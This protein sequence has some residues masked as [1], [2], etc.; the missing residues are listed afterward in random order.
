MRVTDDGSHGRIQVCQRYTTNKVNRR[1][2]SFIRVTSQTVGICS[3]FAVER[4]QHGPQ[5]VSPYPPIGCSIT[6][7]RMTAQC[8]IGPPRGTGSYTCLFLHHI[9][10]VPELRYFIQIQRF[11]DHCR[12][13]NSPVIST[14]QLSATDLKPATFSLTTS[15]KD[16]KQSRN[17]E[18]FL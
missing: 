15:R 3:S 11:E 17:V 5:A 9:R 1:L 14:I 18:N 12:Y 6:N 4:C 8:P 13:P 16:E 10:T 7:H 2:K